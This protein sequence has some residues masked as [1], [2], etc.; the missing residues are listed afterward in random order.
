MNRVEAGDDIGRH[1]AG[2][3]DLI[4]N[5][6]AHRQHVHQAAGVRMLRDDKAAVRTGFDEWETHVPEAFHLMPVGEIAACALR[7]AFDDVS[8]DD[9]GRHPVPV[10]RRPSEL[11]HHWCESHGR[12]GDTAGDDDVGAGPQRRD[13][14]SRP[15]VCVGRQYA[16]A[17]F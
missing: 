13:D 9:A 14:R 3:A 16:I 1:V 4:E 7:A 6:L 8:G 2:R 17:N 15:D 12:V 11:E 5:L 10:G